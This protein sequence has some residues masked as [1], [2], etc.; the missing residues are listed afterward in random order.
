MKDNNGFKALDL[1]PFDSQSGYDIETRLKLSGVK[2]LAPL[3]Q[4]PH[5]NRSTETE[6]GFLDIDDESLP[7]EYDEVVE[8]EY[9]YIVETD[10]LFHDQIIQEIDV[11]DETDDFS[12][13]ASTQSKP[14]ESIEFT[15]DTDN[16]HVQTLK[17]AYSIKTALPNKEE[18]EFIKEVFRK[19]EQRLCEWIYSA[20]REEQLEQKVFCPLD[21]NVPLTLEEINLHVQNDCPNRAIRCFNCQGMIPYHIFDKHVK[22]LCLKRIIACPNAYQGC[23]EMFTFDKKETHVNTQCKLRPMVCR[24]FCESIMPLNVRENHEE[25]HCKNRHIKCDQ[26]GGD[27]IAHEY[28]NHLHN[29]CSERIVH[30]KYACGKVFKSK[31]V[32]AHEDLECVQPC[33]WNCGQILGPNE[34]LKFHEMSECELRPK[35]CKYKCGFPK[36][37]A[38]NIEEHEKY[39]CDRRIVVCPSGCGELVAINDVMNHQDPWIGKCAER[40]IR[41]PHNLVGWKILILPDLSE[42]VVSKYRRTSP[43]HGCENKSQFNGI[44]QIYVKFAEKSVW[45]DYWESGIVLLEF[46]PPVDRNTVV[47]FSCGWILCSD[48]NDHLNHKCEFRNIYIKGESD[49]S[50]NDFKGYQSSFQDVVTTANK[51]KQIDEHIQLLTVPNTTY[52][53]FCSL[54]VASINLSDHL[55]FNCGFS[56]TRCPFGCSAVMQRNLL[57]EHL[58]SLCPKRRVPCPRDCDDK[59]IWAEELEEHVQSACLLRPADCCLGCGASDITVSSEEYH[60]LHTCPWRP[61][62]CTCGLIFKYEKFEEHQSLFCIDRLIFCTLGCGE[63]LKQEFMLNHTEFFCKNKNFKFQA[64]VFCPNG[65]GEEM[66]KRD[67]IQH[68]SYNCP[69][70]LSECPLKC[71]NIFQMDSM[72]GN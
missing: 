25:F 12:S 3:D 6:K 59:D 51:R 9:N 42:G 15:H 4:Q 57:N 36:L 1:V 22:R 29:I 41:C 30:C 34:K 31:D 21:C 55:K 17:D 44:D 37:T 49:S 35:V 7:A 14:I 71:G 62:Q 24:Q 69:K 18:V 33:K 64:Y 70:R 68:V 54:E 16:A 8:R 28:S 27:L 38:F 58:H 26:C 43:L 53:E 67:V 39:H 61:I 60:R 5:D 66:M 10:N 46:H 50:V 13:I 40:S 19:A 11:F 65:C 52:C 20:K 23:T 2:S 45:V 72:R 63:K 47:P 32:K 56:S 48:I